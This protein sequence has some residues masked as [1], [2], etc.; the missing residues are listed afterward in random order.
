AF[1]GN[2]QGGSAHGAARE[3]PVSP[4]AGN[5]SSNDYQRL[6]RKDPDQGQQNRPKAYL[7]FVLFDDQFNLVEDNSGV[8]QAKET[9]DRL[10]TLAV[11]K[12]PITKSG[13]MYVYTSNETEQDVFFDNVTVTTF[14]GPILEDTHYYPFGLVMTGISSNALK[15]TSYQENRLKYNGKE[16]QSKEFGDGS[17]LE[18]YD[19]GA[20]IYDQQIGRWYTID[21]LSELNRRWSP[22]SYTYNNPIR[23]IDPDGML[24]AEFDRRPRVDRKGPEVDDLFGGGIIN[25]LLKLAESENIGR[26]GGRPHDIVD[27]FLGYRNSH[28]DQDKDKDRKNKPNPDHRYHPTP[29]NL[30]GFPDA[31]RVPSKA[32]RARWKLPDGSIL[33]WDK[34]HGEVEKYDKTGKNH[35]G[36]F[37]PETGEQIKGPDKGR[38]TPKFQMPPTPLTGTPALGTL[39]AE[40]AGRFLKQAA[41]VLGIGAVI[42]V[43]EGA[44][45][46]Y[47]I[48]LLSL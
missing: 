3:N 34:Q 37:D 38:T 1:G 44:A 8:R 4:F 31:V 28:G 10:Q 25:N 13:F 29:K 45:T 27:E 48:P 30:P 20:R 35:Q 7:N 14:S 15:G 19:Y 16:L 6:S 42:I 24:S 2:G 21:P 40:S 47:V 39:D 12:M 11:D 41:V 18:W 22:Y 32:D 23:F 26:A 36:A 43:S 5:F 17:G 46:P 33:E 9:P